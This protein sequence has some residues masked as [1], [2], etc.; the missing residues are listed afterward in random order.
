[1]A[2]QSNLAV[3]SDINETVTEDVVVS[4][5]DE[6]GSWAAEKYV[7]EQEAIKNTEQ[8]HLMPKQTDEVMNIVNSSMTK[9]DKIRQLLALGLKRGEV[10]KGLNIK[11]QHVRNVELMPL[12]RKA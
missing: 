8:A 10:A 3:K 6:S 7:A 1:M 9:S 11:Y 2:R 5:I 4:G 12:K